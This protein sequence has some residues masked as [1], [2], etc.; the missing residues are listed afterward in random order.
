MARLTPSKLELMVCAFPVC[1]VFE[2]HRFHMRNIGE[3]RLLELR[4]S[5]D[6]MKARRAQWA[7]PKPNYERGV[8]AN[9]ARLDSHSLMRRIGP[10]LRS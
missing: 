7:P 9:Y 6:E 4:A 10:C 8:L 3:N 2:E 5:E 1:S